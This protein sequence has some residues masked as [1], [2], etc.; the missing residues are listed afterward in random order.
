[1]IELIFL[2][3]KERERKKERELTHSIHPTP[4]FFHCTNAGHSPLTLP[5]SRVNDG[6]CDCCD[7]SDEYASQ[8][9]CVD[10]CREMGRAARE[11]AVKKREER[12]QGFQLRQAMIE[13]GHKRK[14][15]AEVC[16]FE[17]CC[18]LL[19]LNSVLGCS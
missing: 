2:Q 5:S 1:M 16:A 14:K 9:N 10:V 7:A 6:V 19:T 13:D 15:E 12:L 17:F 3:N 18:C 4:G 11:E 8:A